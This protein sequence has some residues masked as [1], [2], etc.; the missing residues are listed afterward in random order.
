LFYIFNNNVI[1]R[2][3]GGVSVTMFLPV[4]RGEEKNTGDPG[5]QISPSLYGNTIAKYGGK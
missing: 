3:E 1:K 5:K 2:W 4:S